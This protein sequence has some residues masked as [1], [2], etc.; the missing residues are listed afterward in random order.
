MM[1]G[2]LGLGDNSAR[3]LLFFDLRGGDV[4][5]EKTLSRSINE[6]RVNRELFSL[7]AVLLPG[8]RVGVKEV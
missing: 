6:Q 8:R 1:H 3:R 2:A 7:P 4:P 5:N